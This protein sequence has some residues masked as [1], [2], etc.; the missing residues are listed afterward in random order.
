MNPM[1]APNAM[2]RAVLVLA[3]LVPAASHAQSTD[4]WKFEASLY[5]FFPTISGT[6][7][8]P[9][10]QTSSSVRVD[11]WTILDSVRMT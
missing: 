9:P 3:C 8:F 2:A 6:A 1:R 5:A 7:T 10:Q 4:G 11:I